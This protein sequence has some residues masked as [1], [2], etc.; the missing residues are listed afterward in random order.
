M[1]LSE[2]V[3]FLII[4]GI[5]LI[6]VSI[7]IA[8]R[9]TPSLLR[10]SLNCPTR[11]SSLTTVSDYFS[12]E[13]NKTITAI[14]GQ[15]IEGFLP[16]M[17]KQAF[18][19]LQLSDFECVEAYKG[20]YRLKSKKI[21]FVENKISNSH[22]SAEQSITPYGIGKLLENISNRLRL[23]LRTDKDVDVILKFISQ[24]NNV[25]SI[26]EDL[27]VS[28]TYVCLPHKDTKNPQTMECA[29]GLLTAEGTYYALDLQKLIPHI[30]T[31]SMGEKVTVTGLFVRLEALSTDF[32]Q[33]YPIEGII[34]VS[35]VSK[36]I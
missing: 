4:C 11:S 23:P 13:I 36:I 22:S 32:W 15:P 5:F 16:L 35:S 28:G 27:T 12:K 10:E 34:S 8:Y 26:S 7:V 17:I 2:P 3:K 33:K 25:T 9:I 24:S 31:V 18:P 19:G 29:Y 21:V 6:A 20:Q 30:P 1:K 14:S